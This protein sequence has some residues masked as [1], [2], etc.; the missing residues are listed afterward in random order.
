MLLRRVWIGRR[1]GL[2]DRGKSR[3]FRPRPKCFVFGDL[4]FVRQRR[5]QR[6]VRERVQFVDQAV[7]LHAKLLEVIAEARMQIIKL[8][9]LG[10]RGQQA[11][12]VQRA[13]AVGFFGGADGVRPFASEIFHADNGDRR[14]A[15]GIACRA[16]KKSFAR[17]SLRQRRLRQK[18][19]RRG[20]SL[21]KMPPVR[22]RFSSASE[23][24]V[25]KVSSFVPRICGAFL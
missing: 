5:Q 23:A 3:F 9:G 16:S 20:S 6:V 24:Y 15:A 2:E 18:T 1:E 11:D 14:A 4:I 12:E 8:V 22:G 21:N 7:R 25:L 17:P 10:E 19:V 13:D